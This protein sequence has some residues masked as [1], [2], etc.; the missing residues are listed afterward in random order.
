MARK[1][2]LSGNR[3][4]PEIPTEVLIETIVEDAVKAAAMPFEHWQALSPTPFVSLAIPVASGHEIPVTQSGVDAAHKLTDQT[5][6]AREE[7]RQRS[8]REEFNKV[9]FTAIGE[10]LASIGEHLPKEV[11][12]DAGAVLDQSVF[13]ALADDYDANLGRL[14]QGTWPDLDQHFPCHLF[15]SDQAV[16]AFSVGPVDFRPR[17]DWIGQFVTTADVRAHIN[18]VETGAMRLEELRKQARAPGAAESLYR[19]QSIL[20]VLG[21]FQWVATARILGHAP[22][23]SRQKAAII[24]ALAIDAIGLRFQVEDARRFTKA[25]RQHLF[26][27]ERLSTTMS[28]NFMR[29]SSVQ[30]PGLGS[31]PGALAAKMTAERPFL[32]AAGVILE[33][34]VRG[35]Q[36]GRAPHLI[37]RWANALYWVGEARREESDFMAVVKYGCAADVLSGAGG[38]ATEMTKFAEAALNPK[39]EPTPVD[40]LSIGKA[41]ET[42]YVG[43][44]N[45]LAHGEMPGLFEDLTGPR[46]IGDQLLVYLFDVCTLKLAAAVKDRPRFFIVDEK[47]A[48]IAF[49]AY[50]RGAV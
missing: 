27:E 36:T 32:D 47:A 25:G 17:A 24:V 19:A 31:K 45:K 41:V 7:L 15:H 5:W 39:G 46:T 16:P 18:A 43:G 20:R 37:E 49:T 12:E 28:G 4:P 29:G 8:T 34:Y 13:K 22:T 14:S 2:R 26:A 40:E 50:L 11:Q 6:M 21:G 48:Y 30:M 10:A 3:N 35:R 42:V 38:K 44:R 1:D 33:A 23:Q 9:S